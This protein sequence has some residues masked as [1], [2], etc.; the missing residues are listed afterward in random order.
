MKGIWLPTLPSPQR[1]GHSLSSWRSPGCAELS[2]CC[3]Q[4]LLCLQ[5]S[6]VWSWGVWVWIY[7]LLLLVAFWASWRC[8][9][10]FIINFGKFWDSIS[11]KLLLAFRKQTTML[12]STPCDRGQPGAP[13]AESAPC[14]QAARKQAALPVLQETECELG[15][16]PSLRWDLRPRQHLGFS[17]GRLWAENAEDMCQAPDHKTVR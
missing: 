11:S 8:G 12:K 13:C 7:F 2:P 16:K 17:R 4:D 6:V 1:E 9:F 10:M 15:E 5:L 3:F 14:W